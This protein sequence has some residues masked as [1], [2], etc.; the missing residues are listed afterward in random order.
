MQFCLEVGGLGELGGGGTN[1]IYIHVSKC[2]NDKTK[3]EK[4]NLLKKCVMFL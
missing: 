2:K 1:N 4:I 3:G